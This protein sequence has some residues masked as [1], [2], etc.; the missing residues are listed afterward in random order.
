M[1]RVGQRR[2]DTDKY[3]HEETSARFNQRHSHL[4]YTSDVDIDLII[5]ERLLRAEEY[6]IVVAISED[7]SLF[8]RFCPNKPLLLQ[9]DRLSPR[10]ILSSLFHKEIVIHQEKMQRG[11]RSGNGREG[12]EEAGATLRHWETR[13]ARERGT[14]SLDGLRGLSH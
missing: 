2:I 8:D 1:R 10:T 3:G 13:R 9:Q 4:P 11:P 7:R 12:G 6:V 14:R 5:R